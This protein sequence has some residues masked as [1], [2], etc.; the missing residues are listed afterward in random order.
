MGALERGVMSRFCFW[1][2]VHLVFAHIQP[3][4][5]VVWLLVDRESDAL[6]LR[7]QRLS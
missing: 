4:P 3:D 5:S 6:F 1:P 7:L 2:L